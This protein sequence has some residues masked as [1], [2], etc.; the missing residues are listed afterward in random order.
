MSFFNR[1]GH[2][3]ANVAG[4]A[5][6]ISIGGLLLGVIVAVITESVGGLD[7]KGV[8]LFFAVLILAATVLFSGYPREILLFLWPVALTYNRQY[9][10]LGSVFGDQGS[11]GP[12]WNP[13][14]LP[15]LA[16]LIIW[17]YEVLILKRRGPR[18]SGNSWLWYLP[19]ALAS[20]A[21]AG[22]AE[23][24]DWALFELIRFIKIGLI[25]LYFQYNMNRTRWWVTVS[26][27]G[28]GLLIQ[29]LFSFLEVIAHRKGI[30]WIFGIDS[31]YD[32]SS[33]IGF[34]PESYFGF[35]RASGTMGHP[36]YLA[37]YMLLTL[38]VMIALSLVI[39][40]RLLKLLSIGVSLAGLAAFALT[41]SRWPIAMM[42]VQ[43]PSL[44]FGLVLMR[45]LS[46]ARALGILII[47][48]TL[49]MLVAVS[50]ADRI[51]ERLTSDFGASV[52][53]R[54]NE[55]QVALHMLEDHPLLGVG[56]NN[57]AVQMK[58]YGSKLTWALDKKFQT[59]ATDVLHLR[60]VAGPL[61]SYLY[62]AATSGLIGLLTFLYFIL[63][64]L[65]IGARAVQC[66][67]GALKAACWGMVVGLAGI[68]LQQVLD[69]SL[70]IDPI[71]YAWTM[72]IG[73][74]A[75]AGMA[76]AGSKKAPVT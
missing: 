4:R 54:F 74:L 36:P 66:A 62:V 67:S 19:F 22:V 51:S 76:G 64:T 63:G 69:Y 20:L 9:F 68:Y 33:V 24:V 31:G 47:A 70:W 43:L 40:H 8:F 65:V 48:A 35:V 56:L 41:L 3:A 53:L 32:V 57:Y 45:G 58:R 25:L 37:N 73:L 14:D 44:I 29:S 39:K 7:A 46:L 52:D 11:F 34:D 17:L 27:F 13:S 15:F 38:P 59:I 61:N 10:S 2:Q 21:S 55:Y 1:L 30:M 18:P 75:T 72:I 6:A 12:Y 50:L 16:L 23:R 26:G 49:V 28:F 60:I 71:L 5:L 42:A